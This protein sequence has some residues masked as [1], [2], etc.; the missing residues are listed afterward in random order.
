MCVCVC[1]CVCV[2]LFI[3][4][5]F[6]LHSDVEFLLQHPHLLSW[7]KYFLNALVRLRYTSSMAVQEVGETW[8]FGLFN[9]DII[10]PSK[11]GASDSPSPYLFRILYI[12]VI[13]NML[14]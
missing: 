5:F 12:L 4:F 10:W 6:F 13:S 14:K 11:I 1:V 8:I 2:C 3:F 9:S 7:R